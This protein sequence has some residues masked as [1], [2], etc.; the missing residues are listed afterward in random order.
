MGCG[1][2]VHNTVEPAFHNGKDSTTP[3]QKKSIHNEQLNGPPSSVYSTV[4][5]APFLFLQS[6]GPSSVKVSWSYET[7]SDDSTI[8]F[9]LE[10]ETGVGK[11]YVEVFRSVP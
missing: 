10:M 7:V 6:I 1:S 8:V 3:N 9:V 5:P 2:S 4:L 11:G